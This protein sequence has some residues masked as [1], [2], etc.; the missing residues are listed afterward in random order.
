MSKF[1]RSE[2]WAAEPTRRAPTATPSTGVCGRAATSFQGPSLGSVPCRRAAPARLPVPA[3]CAWVLAVPA[4]QRARLP[5]A[6]VTFVVK[7]K[8]DEELRYDVG[9][10]SV[11]YTGHSRTALP[12]APPPALALSLTAER[13]TA[14]WPLDP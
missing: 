13:D 14:P 10:R 4:V 1:K 3:P 5:V 2:H 12:L 6:N 9:V 8:G 11:L 7:A